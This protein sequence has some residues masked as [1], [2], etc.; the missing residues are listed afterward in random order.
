MAWIIVLLI[1]FI[2]GWGSCMLLDLF[3]WRNKRICPEAELQ[4][5]SAV[6]KLESDKKYLLSKLAR[7]TETAE[8]RDIEIATQ[9]D[10][11]QALKSGSSAINRGEHPNIS[12]GPAGQ[13]PQA[14]TQ[15]MDVAAMVSDTGNVIHSTAVETTPDTQVFTTQELAIDA[16]LEASTEHSSQRTG[17]LSS[18]YFKASDSVISTTEENSNSTERTSVLALK[19]D[20]RACDPLELDQRISEAK[21]GVDKTQELESQ[22]FENSIARRDDAAL[23]TFDRPSIAEHSGLASK[24][25]TASSKVHEPPEPLEVNNERASTDDLTR[26]WGIGRNKQQALHE[27]GICTFSAL[28]ETPTAALDDF[29]AKGGYRYN[30]ANQ[31]TWSEQ[32]RLAASGR[33]VELR[34][35]QEKLKSRLLQEIGGFALH[36]NLKVIWGIG[37][38]KQRALHRVGI[39][40][41]KQ[42]ATTPVSFFDNLVHQGR[43][44]FN[45]AN[46]ATWQEQARLAA[47]EQWAVL[48]ALQRRLKKKHE[49]GSDDL[50]TIYGIGKRKHKALN[51]AGIFSFEQ[52]AAAPVAE[53]DGLVA[54]GRGDFNHNN[55]ATWP[56]QAWLAVNK[57]WG[58]LYLLQEKLKLEGVPET[59]VEPGARGDNLRL[60]WGIG[61][62]KQS[63]LSAAGIHSFAQFA[64]M[65]ESELDALV[66]Q[67]RDGFNL[68]NQSS[69][70]QQAR[71]AAELQW[72]KLR[73]VQKKL[74]AEDRIRHDDLRVIFGIGKKKQKA[75]HRL[76]IYT[77][78]QLAT[79]P[80]SDFDALIAQ[81][82]DHFNL[83]NQATWSKQAR[84]AVGGDWRA[85]F[86]YQQTL[87]EHAIRGSQG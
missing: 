37:K 46:Q 66:A 35:L 9:R 39:Y 31:A 5:S 30:W 68:A 36:D 60:I 69:W 32:A 82:K 55:Q 11:D 51:Q 77:F 61:K 20:T 26:I 23:S 65:G 40:I 63:A 12:S 43:G 17:I 1:G 53:L 57:Q 13:A 85:F 47:S 10:L 28:M 80:P 25:M 70:S 41:F 2:L 21:L 76:G 14:A 59:P 44:E 33:W 71:L 50:R 75:L 86:E 45:L 81:G 24:T 42:L 15:L 48:R 74:K 62:R 78:E 52:L 22:D 38:L 19:V 49:A 72:D 34:E 56:E 7:L 83:S 3:F 27:R 54:G 16:E 87:R 18:E 67:G 64:A 79:T 84:L 6:N 8:G 4:L 73:D 58:D 29:V